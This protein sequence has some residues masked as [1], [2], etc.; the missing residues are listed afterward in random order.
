MVFTMVAALMGMALGPVA[1]APGDT[2][3]AFSSLKPDSQPGYSTIVGFG[4]EISGSS[5]AGGTQSGASRFTAVASGPIE[6]ILV[7]LYGYGAPGDEGTARV[8]LYTDDGGKIGGPMK[9][10]SV[11]GVLSGVFK[12]YFAFNPTD[13]ELVLTKGKSYWL[14]VEP[15]SAHSHVVWAQGGGGVLT[16]NLRIYGG[17]D[18]YETRPNVAYLMIV[19]IFEP[20]V[21]QIADPGVALVE[22]EQVPNEAPKTPLVTLG[23]GAQA[24]MLGK[25]GGKG[26]LPVILGSDGKVKLRV[27]ES[28]PTLPGTVVTKLKEPCGNAVLATLK[29]Q[30]AAGGAAAITAANDTVLI[31]GIQTGTLSV[32][33]RSGDPIGGA[34]GPK[35]KAFTAID[36]N[37]T[38]VFFLATLTGTGVGPT[39]DTALLAV[40]PAAAARMLVREGDLINTKKVTTIATLVGLAGTLAEGRWR[41][42][43]STIGVR[44]TFDD[45]NQ[46]IYTIPGTAADPSAWTAYAGTT[47]TLTGG[48]M[49][50]KI[51]KLSYPGFGA[52]GPV[53]VAQLEVGTASVAKGDD[54]VVL[55]QSAAG[56]DLIAREGDEAVDA[57]GA[58]ITGVDFVSFGDPIAGAAGKVAF[59][60][61][62]SSKTGNAGVW[63]KNGSGPLRLVARAGDLA[64]G[65]GTFSKFNSLVLPDAASS[66]PIFQ[67]T[68]ATQAA[69]GI[70]GKTSGGVW[71]VNTTG[72]LKLVARSGAYLYLGNFYG[73]TLS[74][75]ALTTSTGSTGAAHGIDADGSVRIIATFKDIQ[76]G[77]VKRAQTAVPVPAS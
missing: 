70:N 25:I 66:G 45:K 63:W 1:G 10:Y 54:L 34:G 6:K 16:K 72:D 23:V 56:T 5:I 73:Y 13:T 77:K 31:G 19:D 32:L 50:A 43:A 65:V 52:A 20:L 74:L 14:S 49:G 38:T 57:S 62:L 39:T 68:L 21:P 46:R 28:A 8:I 75:T 4:A 42:D 61:K 22:G 17:S 33:A 12:G 35:L 37:G 29:H 40:P 48:V 30:P 44:L 24:P 11:A 18:H 58:A 2:H 3:T 71:G 41:V 76:T 36:G 67:A 7:A 69:G 59:A 64:P 26:A 15:A 55:R 9:V 60:A 53:F 27:G 51:S 47:D